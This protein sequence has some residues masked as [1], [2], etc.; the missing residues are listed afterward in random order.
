MKRT[1]KTAV[2]GTS[3]F[4]VGV[5]PGKAMTGVNGPLPV[6]FITKGAEEMPA[7]A[8]E[9]VGPAAW[10]AA[11]IGVDEILAM[12]FETDGAVV[13]AAAAIDFE[14]IWVMA[15]GTIDDVIDVEKLAT[16]ADRAGTGL[17]ERLAMVVERAGATRGVD[18]MLTRADE[19]IE[20]TRGVEELAKIV[21]VKVEVAERA[22]TAR[23]D[24]EIPAGV[25]ESAGTTAIGV[26]VV[27]NVN[28][29]MVDFGSFCPSV[30][31]EEDIGLAVVAAAATVCVIVE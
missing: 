3:T 29:S 11:A 7:I 4:V 8:A 1:R 20:A 13:W 26:E 19:G 30:I 5:P 31:S 23:G 24:D 16:V 21:D 15:S 17:D 18:E 6:C 12:A 9:K 28:T 27:A 22:G 14:E 2:T 25:A 10:A